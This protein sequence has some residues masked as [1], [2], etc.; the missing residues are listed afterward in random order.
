MIKKLNFQIYLILNNICLNRH[1]WVMATIL[2]GAD[3]ENGPWA[4]SPT[5]YVTLGKSPL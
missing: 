4:P 5:S 3:L 2:G 1:M